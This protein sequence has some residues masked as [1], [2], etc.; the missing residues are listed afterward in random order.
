MS[1]KGC[2]N[3]VIAAAAIAAT[4]ARTAPAQMSQL[5]PSFY[6]AT[7]L[8]TRSSQFYLLGMYVGVGGLGWSPYFNVNGYALHYRLDK[9]VPSSARTLSA[10]L[11]T[12]GLAYAA[13]NGGVS[14]G[15]GYAWV[16]N[17]DSGAPGAEGGGSNGV[18][19][20]LGAYHSG[21]GPRA[22]HTQL[23]SNYNFDSKYLWARGR[24]SVPFGRSR[25]H[26]ARIG[27]EAVGQSGGK[28][29]VKSNS[30]QVGPTLEYAWTP[31]LRTTGAVGYKSVGGER[32][33]SRENAAYLKLE[34]SFSP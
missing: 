5:H 29:G 17:E 20:S 14:F 21:R 25:L 13:R 28:D 24:A 16:H 30:W 11:P 23:L 27:A 31:Q 12:L 32:F 1:L 3:A 7:E 22:L 2:R 18:T 34:F 26:P 33:A 19:A 4:F 8:D 15:A 6:G 10:V 9:D